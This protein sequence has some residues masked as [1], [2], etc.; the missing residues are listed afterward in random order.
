MVEH[1]QRRPSAAEILEAACVCNS[2][3][4]NLAADFY[5]MPTNPIAPI[6]C[7]LVNCNTVQITLILPEEIRGRG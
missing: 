5:F 1:F 7:H 6:F 2:V 4:L 3:G